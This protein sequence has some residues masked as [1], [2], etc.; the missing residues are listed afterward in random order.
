MRRADAK[1]HFENWKMK[2]FHDSNAISATLDYQNK[3][4]TRTQHFRHF[5]VPAPLEVLLG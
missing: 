2:K 1:V 4:L 3:A 5:F